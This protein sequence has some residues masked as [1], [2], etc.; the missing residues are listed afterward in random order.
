MLLSNEYSSL[1]Q[2]SR[3]IQY[4][5]HMFESIIVHTKYTNQNWFAITLYMSLQKCASSYERNYG[6]VYNSTR[7]QCC[8]RYF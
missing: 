7:S 8:A 5:V 3:L 2:C 4:D 6:I 1:L